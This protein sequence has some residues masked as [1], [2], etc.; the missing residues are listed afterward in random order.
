MEHNNN[1]RNG[2]GWKTKDVVGNHLAAPYA[3]R[4]AGAEEPSIDHDKSQPRQRRQERQRQYSFLLPSPGLRR[5]GRK[6][7]RKWGGWGDGN[8]VVM[9]LTPRV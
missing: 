2:G 6:R 4:R 3:A 1:Q 7:G 5:R 9:H 8:T